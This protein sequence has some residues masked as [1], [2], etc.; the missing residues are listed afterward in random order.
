MRTLTPEE[1][2][3]YYDHFGIKQ[4]SQS[5]YE[6]PALQSLVVNSHFEQ[7]TSVFEFGCGTGAFALELFTHHLTPAA[8]YHGIDISTTMIQL[9]SARLSDFSKRAT[10]ELASEGITAP[11]G[12]NSADRFVSNYVLDLLAPESVVKVLDEARRIL[13]PNGLLCLVSLTKG[14]TFTSR[15]TMGI[16]QQLFSTNPSW[17]GGCRPTEL[18]DYLPSDQWQI[19]HRAIIIAWGIPSEVIVAA[20]LKTG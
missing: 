10:V 13:Q 11:V 9:A 19:H 6:A 4:D 20:P 8:Q 18:M 1:A 12:D 3:S 16:W 15:L 17:V 14:V 7:A 5:F 2:K